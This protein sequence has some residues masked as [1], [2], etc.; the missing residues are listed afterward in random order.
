M[1]SLDDYMRAMWQTHGEPGGPA[2]GL[3]EV[4]YTLGDARDRL[5]EITSDRAFADDFFDRYVEGHEVV[6]YA[7]LLE[8]AGL[9]LRKRA[10]GRAWLG[11][12]RLAFGD[13]G[14]RVT[15]P[16]PFGS[17]MYAA[18]LELDDLVVSF[19][20]ETNLR[21]QRR[22]TQSLTN[23]RPG[24]RVFVKFLRGG[25]R[26]RRPWCSKKTHASSSCRSRRW[27]NGSPTTSVP[28]RGL[29]GQSG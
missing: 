4:P 3:V 16:V 19:D 12:V 22:F 15:A 8:R 24:D 14:A 6:D 1:V 29:A 23:R 17:P 13:D 9:M 21:S 10:P 20:G 25:P 7:R 2:P 5:A 28:S 18:G 27:A 11:D 26:R